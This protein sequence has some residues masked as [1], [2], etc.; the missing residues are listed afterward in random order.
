[1]KALSSLTQFSF[2]AKYLTIIQLLMLNVIRILSPF[3]ARSVSKILSQFN[4]IAN[5]RR[6]KN[7]SFGFE[8]IFRLLTLF[9]QTD[10]RLV[11]QNKNLKI[12]TFFS[13]K[14]YFLWSSSNDVTQSVPWLTSTFS[15]LFRAKKLT[16]AT[17]LWNLELTSLNKTAILSHLCAHFVAQIV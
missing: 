14:F 15:R 13:L 3:E 12:K 5:H 17:Y 11:G 8:L 2:S 10:Y 7:V 1:M 9:R 6:S 4:K 16:D